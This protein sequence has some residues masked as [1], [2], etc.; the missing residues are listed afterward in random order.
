MSNSQREAARSWIPTILQIATMIFALGIAYNKLDAFGDELSDQDEAVESNKTAIDN[1]AGINE[2]VVTVLEYIQRD[3]GE[4]ASDIE[5]L[6]DDFKGLRTRA[7]A[8]ADKY[9]H[10]KVHEAERAVVSSTEKD[11]RMLEQRVS[12]LESRTGN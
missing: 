10:G 2:R 1:L 11:V 7:D 4:N 12:R 3:V 9:A 5:S 6:S 8:N